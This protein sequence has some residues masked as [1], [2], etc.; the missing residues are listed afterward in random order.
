VEGQEK[1]LFPAVCPQ[2]AFKLAPAPLT[3]PMVGSRLNRA[4]VF[5]EPGGPETDS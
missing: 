3:T 2:P 5:G 4:T 1:N